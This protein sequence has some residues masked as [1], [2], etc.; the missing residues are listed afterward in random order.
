M[1]AEK[2]NLMSSEYL[3]SLSSI[4]TVKDKIPKEKYLKYNVKRGLRNDNGTGV[5]VGLT[6]IGEVSGYII[7]DNEKIATPGNLY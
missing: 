5:L 6:S 4:S 3:E 1:T 7:E 2:N